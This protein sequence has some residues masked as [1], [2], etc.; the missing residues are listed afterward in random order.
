MALAQ[1]WTGG[2]RG[3]RL[4]GWPDLCSTF[5]DEETLTRIIVGRAE[6]DLVEIKQAFFDTY[7]KSLPKRIDVSAPGVEEEGGG[8]LD[9]RPLNVFGQLHSSRSLQEDTRGDYGKMLI[10]VCAGN[11]GS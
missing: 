4:R 10:A 3:E 1:V 9:V 7:N 8:S 11:T 2:G 5:A 6:K